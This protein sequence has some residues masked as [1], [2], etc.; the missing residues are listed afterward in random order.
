MDY[1]D[2][3]MTH[4]LDGCAHAMDLDYYVLCYGWLHPYHIYHVLEISVVLLYAGSLAAA[5][6]VAHVLVKHFTPLSLSGL[7]L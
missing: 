1:H 5:F 7:M 2:Y 3:Y 4:S 6:S